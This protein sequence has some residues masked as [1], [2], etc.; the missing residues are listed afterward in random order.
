MSET[1]SGAGRREVAY[2]MFAAEFDDADFSYSESDEDRAPNYVVTPTGARANRLFIVGV[3]T[4]VETVSEDVLRARVVDPTGAFV[5][6]AG[7]YQPDEQAFLE[8][9]QP[10]T[11]VAVT[12][13]ARTFTPDDSDQVFTSIRPESISEVDAE[14]R[15]RWTVQAAEQTLRRIEWMATALAMDSDTLRADLEAR[16]ADEGLAHG[17]E[18]ALDHYGTTPTYLDAVREMALDAA[19]VVAGEKDE[20]SAH[21]AA[22]DGSGSVTATDLIGTA[23]AETVDEATTADTASQSAGSNATEESPPSAATAQG[24]SGRAESAQQGADSAEE[25]TASAAAETAIE[26]PGEAEGESPETTETATTEIEAELS[27]APEESRTD[28]AAVQGD[29]MQDD[30]IEQTESSDDEDLGDFEPGEFE[31]EEETRAEIESE[32]GTEFQ[33]GTEVEEPGNADIETPEPPEDAEVESDTPEPDS[34][35]SEPDSESDSTTPEPD[36]EQADVDSDESPAEETDTADSGDDVE[37]PADLQATVVELMGE[38]DEGDGAPRGELIAAMN[39]RY[40][41]DSEAVEDAIQSA[42]MDGECYEP[43][44][45]SLKPI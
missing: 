35:S 26:S 22:P 6:Y 45:S 15:D 33:S 44:D 12:G 9:T 10:P 19:R 5:L 42:L 11:F 7:Q 29:S 4:E 21:T 18:L 23:P 43:D 28:E 31:L 32:Y 36:S 24:D 38:L 8:S 20:I 25:T 14:T 30:E 37:E 16:G 27:D 13:K 34:T 40:G 41:T 3:L 39:E 1:E 17:I 2:R